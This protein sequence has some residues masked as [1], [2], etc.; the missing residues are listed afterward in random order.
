[1]NNA[2]NQLFLH[3]IF[4]T[5]KNININITINKMLHKLQSPP[6]LSSQHAVSLYDFIFYSSWFVCK[7]VSVKKC[8]SFVIKLVPE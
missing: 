8:R 4:A 2:N 5:P 3:E 6:K 7:K 1:M